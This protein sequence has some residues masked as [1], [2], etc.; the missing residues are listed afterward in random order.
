MRN[1]HSGAR[2]RAKNQTLAEAEQAVILSAE[3]AERRRIARLADEPPDSWDGPHVALRLPQAF[4]TLQMIPARIRPAEY[5]SS[6]PRYTH[7]WADLLAQAAAEAEAQEHRQ[8]LKNRAR[9]MPTTADITR[10][11]QLFEAVYRVRESDVN[12]G[13]LLLGWAFSR[14]RN[15]PIATICDRYKISRRKF[16]RVLQSAL[17]HCAERLNS[18]RIAPW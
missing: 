13:L 5:G 8:R 1:N 12:E 7:D 16:Y 9:V 6:M 3:E 15:E 10:M 11:E 2:M 14:Y 4:R 17:N 18:A